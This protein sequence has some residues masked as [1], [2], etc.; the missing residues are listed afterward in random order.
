MNRGALVA[1]SLDSAVSS[2]K[3]MLSIED[4]DYDFFLLKLADESIRSIASQK[5]LIKQTSIL[6]IVN[7][8]VALPNGF[9]RLVAVSVAMNGIPNQLIYVDS[10]YISGQATSDSYYKGFR[11]CEIIGDELILSTDVTSDEVVMTWMGYN[12]GEKCLMT[13]YDYQERAVVAY[14]CYKFAL[15]YHLLIHRDIRN[16]YKAEYIAQKAYI[17]GYEFTS[18]FEEQKS[19]LSFIYNA[20]LIDANKDL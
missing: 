4:S 12:L 1:I 3:S 10:T 6:P 19:E 15:K 2:A 9:S 18:K 16:E 7:N 11:Q 13:M 17:R 5:K 20:L 8:R 14:I